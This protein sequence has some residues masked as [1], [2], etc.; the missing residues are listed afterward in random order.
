MSTD[1]IFSIGN[2]H[3]RWYTITVL[4]GLL[5]GYWRITQEITRRGYSQSR[6]ENMYLYGL[7]GGFIVARVTWILEHLGSY[8]ANPR[9]MV[10]FTDGGFDLLGGLWGII[11]M[12]AL[13]SRGKRMSVWRLMDAALPEVILCGAVARFGRCFIWPKN[14][15]TVGVDLFLWYWIRKQFGTYKPGRKRGMTAVVTVLLFGL[16]RVLALAFHLDPMVRGTQWV[17]TASEIGGLFL[18]EQF[19]KQKVKK[20]VIL[21]D[22][23]GT[24]L[25][26]EEMILLCFEHLYEL[27]GDMKDF[28]PDLRLE[29][30]GP[31]LRVEIAKLFPEKDTDQ[32]MSEYQNYQRS[33]LGTNQVQ[34]LP[35]TQEVLESLYQE[36]YVMG[37]VSSRFADSCQEWLKDREIEKYFKLVLGREGYEEAKPEPDGVL[38]ALYKLR[39]TRDNA[40]Y[41]GDNASDVEA[42]R[43]AGVFS[44]GIVSNP[45]KFSELQKAKPNVMISDL[46]ELLEILKADHAWT[47]EC[48]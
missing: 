40:V 14:F 47:Y 8:L 21:F 4:V 12:I 34:L 41:V 25:D 29:V 30:I 20:P 16:S 31:P 22:F 35:H 39:G 28:T 42:G 36:G 18:Y 19:K 3:I 15:A 23:D 32:L 37:I 2:L 1:V 44:V 9:Q 13:Y 5:L 27:H 6:A 7:L 46:Q 48:L 10:L 43:R 11:G 45:A 33:L 38:K 17:I 26:S 24:L